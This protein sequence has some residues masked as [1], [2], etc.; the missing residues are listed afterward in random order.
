MLTKYTHYPRHLSSKPLGK[1]I[2][3]RLPASR[4]YYVTWPRASHSAVG[5]DYSG[6]ANPSHRRMGTGPPALGRA[7]A[8]DRGARPIRLG[9]VQRRLSPQ[10]TSAGG[11][12]GRSNC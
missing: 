7:I 8:G 3:G 6:L 9:A 12:A 5:V 2:I 1:S 10:F 11:P 4:N